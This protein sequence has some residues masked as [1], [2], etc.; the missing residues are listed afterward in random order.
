MTTEQGADSVTIGNDP[1]NV[2]VYAGYVAGDFIN[3]DALVA[4]HPGKKFI[5]ITPFALSGPKADCLDIEP[6]DSVPANAPTFFHEWAPL[7]TNK[8]IFYASI[9]NMSDVINALTAAGIKRDQYYLWEAHYDG[10]D[11]IPTGYD[12]AQY[13]TGT[14]DGDVFSAYMWGPLT[15]PVVPAPGGLKN[16]FYI[17]GAQLFTAWDAVKGVGSYHVQIE[18]LEETGWVLTENS[19][20]PVP[21]YDSQVYPQKTSLRWRVST[22]NPNS[23]WPEWQV[24]ETP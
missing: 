13:K 4:A 19:T 6:G 16:S 22:L 10:I 15:P 1:S 3:Y 2:A 8:P 23:A 18:R 11:L 5:A 24:V 17:T 12:A 20:T 21:N 9:D 14:F 7:N